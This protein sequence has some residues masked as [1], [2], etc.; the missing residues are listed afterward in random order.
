MHKKAI[1]LITILL[2]LSS[3]VFTTLV[4]SALS[5][6]YRTD[7]PTTTHLE[8]ND[9]VTNFCYK[10]NFGI[11]KHATSTA[12]NLNLN[13]FPAQLQYNNG[14][15]DFF[16]WHPVDTN[17]VP[18]NTIVYIYFNYSQIAIASGSK[19]VIFS[20]IHFKAG[21]DAH[22]YYILC[23]EDK[24]WTC[25]NVVSRGSGVSSNWNNAE[26]LAKRTE[27]NFTEDAQLIVCVKVKFIDNIRVYIYNVSL[28]QNN[29][30]ILDDQINEEWGDS[31]FTD[32]V[33]TMF[34]VAKYQVTLADAFVSYDAPD[35]LLSEEP[36]GNQGSEPQG[37]ETGPHWL[38]FTVNPP[39]YTIKYYNYSTMEIIKIGTGTLSEQYPYNSTILVKVFSDEGQKKFE[40]KYT[41]VR[42]YDI[43]LDFNYSRPKYNLTV[44]VY[45]EQLREMTADYI[46]V[47]SKSW[48]NVQKVSTLVSEGS[49]RIR[50]KRSGYKEFDSIVQVNSN[51]TYCITLVPETSSYASDISKDNPQT[52][53]TPEDYYYNAS[54]YNPPTE[55][56]ENYYGF[57]FRNEK[58][59]D[60]TVIIYGTKT[61]LTGAW[62]KVPLAEVT[63]P[64]SGNKTVVLYEKDVNQYMAYK[65]GEFGHSFIIEDK[66]TKQKYVE[67]QMDSFKNK[68]RVVVIRE[69]YGVAI[70]GV[71]AS[72]GTALAMPMLSLLYM[73][74]PIM[75]I[76]SLVSAL[77]KMIK[78]STR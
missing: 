59:S 14:K 34:A 12:N 43:Y 30:I 76:L 17:K 53:E 51:V 44:K 18:S 25:K 38:N 48:K 28:I 57:I 6:V 52:P 67:A 2:V 22:G 45:D 5:V 61:T 78:K 64:A 1:A 40:S 4:Y 8:P 16:A 77:T 26:N 21:G 49:H 46:Y 42:D 31:S 39:S 33:L 15:Y 62:Y 27:G 70:G 55:Q 35:V 50:V 54:V 10:G 69:D 3:I 7:F 66:N 24:V 68:F 37:N 75:I 13:S 74:L 23:S 47:D 60:V 58:S 20:M 11:N 36:Q 72:G 73:L 19:A 65:L 32:K 56:E 41:M 71:G 63:I 9:T 29:Q